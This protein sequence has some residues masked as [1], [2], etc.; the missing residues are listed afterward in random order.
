MSVEGGGEHKI[1]EAL[2]SSTTTEEK[3]DMQG[4]KQVGGRTFASIL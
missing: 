2:G 4:Q 1:V 3:E